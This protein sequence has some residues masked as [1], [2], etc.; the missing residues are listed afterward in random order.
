MD[1]KLTT[2]GQLRMAVE[3]AAGEL[4]RA[5]QDVL[6]PGDGITIEGETISVTTPVK[7]VTQAEYDGIPEEERKGVYIVTDANTA[8]PESGEVYS[9]EETRIGTWVDGRPLYQKTFVIDL[10]ASN[11]S[12]TIPNSV[13]ESTGNIIDV[14]GTV[15][16]DTL[17]VALPFDNRSLYFR[18]SYDKNDGIRT[19]N[20]ITSNTKHVY[21]TLKYTKTTDQEVSA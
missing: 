19:A 5:K 17:T 15:S 2:V 10:S 8:L 11:Q 12:S 6:T 9:T 1:K 3:K 14:F 4:D 7:G 18:I 16:F 21:I 13:I 20:N